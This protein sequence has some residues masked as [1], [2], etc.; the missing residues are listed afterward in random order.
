MAAI[1]GCLLASVFTLSSPNG[2]LCMTF[3]NDEGGMR[4]S[5]SR[6]GT[7]IVVP[8]SLGLRFAKSS[9]TSAPEFAPFKVL[10]E[11]RSSCDAVYHPLIYR[12]SELHDCHNE[13]IVELE[14]IE[15]REPMVGM[16]RSVVEKLERRLTMVFRAY[17]EG[18]AL[19]YV[20]PE[21]RC[22]DG[23]ELAQDLTE[24]RF[25]GD[26][27]CYLTEYDSAV[28]PNEM[29]Y[30]RKRLGEVLP[31]KFIGFP[32][33]VRACSGTTLAIT[34]AALVNWAGMY[35]K[36]KTTSPVGEALSAELT[37]LPPSDASSEGT[38]VIRNTPAASPWRVVMVGND[39]LGLLKANDLLYH[40]NP[41]PDPSM[42]FSFVKPG[43]TTWDWWVESNNSLS[44]ELTLKLVD[45]AAERGW[46]YHTI[47]GGWYGF[48]RRPNHGPNVELKPRKDFDLKKIV[49][50]AGSKG[51]GIW[52]WIHWME[53]EDTGIEETFRRMEEWGVVG[54][55]TDFINRQDQWM[56]NWYERVSRA[57]AKHRIMI[58]FHG[59]HK[60]SGT[61]RTWPNNLTREGVLGNE[62]NCFSS[63]N[64]PR[65]SL[66]L[67]FTRF[68][69]GP[70]DYTPGGFGNVY[71]R[72]FVSP[73]KKGHRYGDETDRCSFWT[74][75][76]GTRA[77]SL[78][79]C[80]AYDSYLMTMCDW[81]ERYHDAAGVEALDRLPTVWNRTEPLAGSIG[82]YYVVARETKDTRWYLAAM[83][84]ERRRVETKLDF[85][86]SGEWCAKIYADDPK[87]TPDDAK[88]LVVQARRVT[89]A[90]TIAFDLCAEGGA[91]VVF[92]KGSVDDVDESL[93]TQKE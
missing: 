59:A 14:E 29:E 19:R 24:W 47:D 58:N 86:S 12:R 9:P 87:K 68:L 40:L 93:K 16:G 57:A 48:A 92:E 15:A 31:E 26:P 20:I 71:G 88:A 62:L 10:T 72:D 38:A 1:F 37:P 66:M 53:I 84:V 74:E 64:S 73:S 11:R 13:L 2:S 6:N 45:S 7:T 56:V 50:Y 4:W 33:I 89:S 61:E 41:D 42:D 85:L 28:N 27:E 51:V 8:S 55:K 39:E 34:E 21:Q 91:L 54:V 32:A 18:V 63:R 83:T 22:F 43:A 49:D 60:P 79:Q 82:E 67:P 52:V 25:A 36:H 90:D 80:V 77:F 69:I 5:L 3:E 46:P 44:T 78:A 81:P 23:F 75:Q 30:R 76:M 35:L 17:N 65:H 70:A